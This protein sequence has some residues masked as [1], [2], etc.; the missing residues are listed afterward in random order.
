MTHNPPQFP[1][2]WRRGRNATV[3]DA[4]SK[5]IVDLNMPMDAERIAAAANQLQAPVPRLVSEAG[6]PH[7]I[8]AGYLIWCRDG[9]T[10]VSSIP[11][12]AVWNNV[13]AWLPIP[14]LPQE[15][16]GFDAW[17]QTQCPEYCRN[18]E[19]AKAAWDAAISMSGGKR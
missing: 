6:L 18:R 12:R 5:V 16:S 17:F 7:D 1:L 11:N 10:L 9:T 4:N 19:V 14:P 3:I 2:P 13:I 8:D 15:P